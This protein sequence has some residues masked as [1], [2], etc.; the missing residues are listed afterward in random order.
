[1]SIDLSGTLIQVF[2]KKITSSFE[3]LNGKCLLLNMAEEFLENLWC[4]RST[5]SLKINEL[6]QSS[7]AGFF[8]STQ[9]LLKT[10]LNNRVFRRSCAK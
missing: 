7:L 9:L 2:L 10:R 5:N 3:S 4:V 8:F 1:M 6:N